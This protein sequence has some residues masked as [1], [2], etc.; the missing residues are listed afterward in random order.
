MRAFGSA[1]VATGRAPTGRG[2]GGCGVGRSDRSRGA[3]GRGATAVGV[4]LVCA[5]LGM[6]VLPLA[7]QA[8]QPDTLVLS[9]DD[10]LGIALGANPAVRRAENSLGLNGVET[11]SSLFGSLLPDVQG[12]LFSTTYNGNLQRVALDPLGFPLENPEANWI[13]TSNSG[14]SVTLNWSIQGLSFLNERRRQEQVNRGRVLTLDGAQATLRAD[15]ER[16]YFDA[17]EQR[18]LLSVEEAIADARRRDLETAER[19]FG[20]ARNTQ[21]DVLQAE[22]AVEQQ[23][24]AIQQQRTSYEQALLT[25]R[26][27]LGDTELPA[28]RPESEALPVFDPATLNADGLVARALGDN[29]QVRTAVAGV[30]EARVGVASAGQWKWPTI[31]L[32]YNWGPFLQTRESD[33]FFSFGLEDRVQ[34]SFSA[35]LSIP[36]LND[37]FGSTAAEAQAKVTLDN[38]Q[39][40]LDETR[41]QTEQEVRSQLI[42]LRDQGETL[43]L[44]TRSVEIAEDALRLA[45][46]EYR[47]GT[48]TFEQLQDAVEQEATGR[49]QVIQARYGF[50]D[51]LI[52]LETAVGGPVR[53][54]AGG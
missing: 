52:A 39:E 25:L 30:D 10:A 4:G 48:R 17:L 49:R 28:L 27:T 16:Q 22:L 8:Q 12:N 34:S 31:N 42:N 6:G 33:A 9:L 53:P 38:Q 3:A 7:A 20:L 1:R 19:L 36:F 37:Y 26:T 45:R 29:P 32:R 51:A 50:V 14:Q 2:G 18:E 40:T 54:A 11:R 46:E 43:R 13:Y 47:L 21:V 23:L 15:V 44:A 35:S 24:L 41:L 5:A